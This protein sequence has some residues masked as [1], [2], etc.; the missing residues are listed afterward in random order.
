MDIDSLDHNS[1]LNETT[2]VDSEFIKSVTDT[3]AALNLRMEQLQQ[4][5]LTE[6]P[7]GSQVPAPIGEEVFQD[8][9]RRKSKR[10]KQ[11]TDENHFK[12]SLCII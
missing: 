11:T 7:G 5:L 6:R 1:P 9:L 8:S 12:V 10:G 4:Q 2:P 3:L